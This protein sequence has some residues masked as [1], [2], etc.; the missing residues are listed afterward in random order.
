[1]QERWGWR[2]GSLLLFKTR[3]SFS[4]ESSRRKGEWF[5]DLRMELQVTPAEGNHGRS[6]E[7]PEEVSCEWWFLFTG[8][9]QMGGCASAS[10]H[11]IMMDTWT[12]RCVSV[13][14]D[15]K[16]LVHLGYHSED[17]IDFKDPLDQSD[18]DAFVPCMILSV[19]LLHSLPFLVLNITST[20]IKPPFRPPAWSLLWV[21]ALAVTPQTNFNLFV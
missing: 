13:I 4:L 17:F 12:L 11:C 16:L 10:E 3:I 18:S 19:W 21:L 8:I 9:R 2:S 20:P 15:C 6:L 7:P 1:M 14:F 5:G